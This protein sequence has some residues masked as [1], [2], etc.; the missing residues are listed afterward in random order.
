MNPLPLDGFYCT[1][2][3]PVKSV[4]TPFSCRIGDQDRRQRGRAL[5]RTGQ[6]VECSLVRELIMAVFVRPCIRPLI[7]F[8]LS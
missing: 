1:S 2:F 6:R 5:L 8:C 7:Q 4:F 3:V